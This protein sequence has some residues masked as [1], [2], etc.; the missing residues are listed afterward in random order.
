MKYIN[1]RIVEFETEEE[2]NSFKAFYSSINKDYMKAGE[3]MKLLNISRET[4]CHY[5][6]WGWIEADRFGGQYRYKRDSVYKLMNK[7]SK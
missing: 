2:L 5:K 3:V 4:L 7:T 1:D 6:S